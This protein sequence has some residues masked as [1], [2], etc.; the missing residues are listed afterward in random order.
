VQSTALS[1]LSIQDLNVELVKICDTDIVK[2]A[3]HDTCMCM[4]SAIILFLFELERCI[5][6]AYFWLCRNTRMINVKFKQ[7]VTILKR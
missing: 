4:K 7:F 2:L 1:S 3:S 5:E 6:H